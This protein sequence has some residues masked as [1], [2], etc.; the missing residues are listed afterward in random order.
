MEIAAAIIRLAHSLKVDALA[1]G[2]ETEGQAEF[3]KVCG[4]KLAQGYLFDKPLGRTSCWRNTGLC[5]GTV[6]LGRLNSFHGMRAK[7]GISHDAR[8]HRN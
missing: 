7:R 8:E 1:E 5:E 6:D 3:L 4:C 2:V